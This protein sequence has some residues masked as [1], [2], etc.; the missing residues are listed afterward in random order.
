MPIPA[1]RDVNQRG[2]PPKAPRL[3][4]EDLRFG[5]P[6][7]RALPESS[8]GESVGRDRPPSRK[9]LAGRGGARRSL[10][11]TTSLLLRRWPAAAPL[12]LA[13]GLVALAGCAHY[14]LGTSAKPAFTTLYV[15]PVDS[16]VPLPQGR[17]VVATAIREA[18]LRDGRV[19]LTASPE[20]A[21]ATLRI[22]LV[23]Y[24]RTVLAAN[25]TDT[26]LA[27]EFALNLR[28]SCSL[29]D[30]RSGKPLFAKREITATRSAYVDSGQLQVEYQA[31]P[32]LAEKLADQV[33]HAVLDVW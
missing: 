19:T 26:G 24:D 21:E 20:S 25:S 8:I 3:R 7:G 5:A 12:L 30:N 1:Q 9:A 13:C 2:L 18:F 14:R 27:R 32:L 17:A 31:L 10:L 33:A 22:T 16:R 23:G 29:T 15:A 28:A 6:S 4:H 11:P